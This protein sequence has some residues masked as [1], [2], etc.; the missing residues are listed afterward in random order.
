MK[1]S[2]ALALFLLGAPTSLAYTVGRPSARRSTSLGY[3]LSDDDTNTDAVD[4]NSSAMVPLEQ[5]NEHDELAVRS[6]YSEWVVRHNKIA[7]KERFETFRTN[8]LMQ[9]AWNSRNGLN[10]DLNQYGD[11]TEEEFKQ[12]KASER[13]LL[14]FQQ[15]RTSIEGSLRSK[16]QAITNEDE[17]TYEVV[18]DLR[19]GETGPQHFSY[20]Y[21]KAPYLEHINKLDNEDIVSM[22]GKSKSSQ[23][24]PVLEKFL[25]MI[26]SKLTKK[27]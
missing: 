26:I 24:K 15:S 14:S 21:N 6:E 20:S 13:E 19:L 25:R 5:V 7:S 18:K 8:F 4:F 16:Y 17:R 22:I 1:L 12:F 9:M 2:A 3:I 23:P 10:F 11:F 27:N